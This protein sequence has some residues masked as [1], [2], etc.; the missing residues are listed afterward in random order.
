MCKYIK[1]GLFFKV[2][3]YLNLNFIF[4]DVYL[5]KNRTKRTKELLLS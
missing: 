3:K 4:G 2:Q 1:C 5:D